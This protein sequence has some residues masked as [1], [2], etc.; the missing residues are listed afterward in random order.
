MELKAETT[1][2]AVKIVLPDSYT[3]ADLPEGVSLQPGLLLISFDTEQQ[4]LERLFH[5][6]RVIATKPHLIGNLVKR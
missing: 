2:R 3:L 1:A 6:S 5:F 4:L